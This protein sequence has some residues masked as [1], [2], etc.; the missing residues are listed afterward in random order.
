MMVKPMKKVLKFVSK[1][2]FPLFLIILGLLIFYWVRDY[3]QVPSGI[4]PDFFPKIVAT[5]MIG[6]SV[7]VIFMQLKKDNPGE[8]KPSSK[9]VLQIVYT[10]VSMIALVYIMKY[11]NPI[12]GIALF[13]LGYLKV[14]AGVNWLKTVI[15]SAVGTGLMYL[16]IMVLRIQM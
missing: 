9:N 14:I 11:V 7:I 6:L 8:V 3:R 10:T 16:V 5:L 4:G 1:N 15:I 13:L 12:L 2:S